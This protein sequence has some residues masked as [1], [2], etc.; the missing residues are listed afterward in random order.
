FSATNVKY[1]QFG[2]MPSSCGKCHA[3]MRAA[4]QYCPDTATVW[5]SFWPYSEHP[6]D[7][8]W[9]GCFTSSKTP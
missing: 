7:A 3:E 2:Y 6:T 4:T 8:Y 9:S 5:P 1:D